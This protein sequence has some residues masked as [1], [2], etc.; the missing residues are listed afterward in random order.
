MKLGIRGLQLLYLQF[1]IAAIVCSLTAHLSLQA[2]RIAT[3][4]PAGLK[5]D[6]SGVCCMLV[7]CVLLV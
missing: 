4:I 2:A 5:T 6:V 7:V 1:Q 3:E